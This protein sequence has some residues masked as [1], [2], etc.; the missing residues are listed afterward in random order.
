MGI[1]TS[2]FI[3]GLLAAMVRIGAPLLLAALGAVFTARAGIVNLALEGTMLIGS[4]AGFYGS[5]LTGNVWGGVLFAIIGGIM[6]QLLLA[7][8][9]V[10]VGANQSVAGMGIN[11][12]AL[13]LTTY[14][15]SVMFGVTGSPSSVESFSKIDVPI[16]SDI[17]Y[18]GEIFFH[19]QIL[20]YIAYLLV[21]ICWYVLFKTPFGLNVRAV[22]EHPKVLDIVGKSVVRT[23]V[24]CCV[25]AGALSGLAGAYLSIGELG[26]FTENLTSG[27]GYIAVAAVTFGKWNPIGVMAACLLFGFTDALQLRLQTEGVA[28]APQFLLMLPYIITMI[29]MVAVVGRTKAP[30]SMGRPYTK[31]DARA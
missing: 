10:I 16:L 13:G 24:T 19:H 6:M 4:F 11:M 31:H 22:G 1:F 25:I 23:R 3:V 14:L 28:I 20:V 26:S 15:L 12:F 5:Y 17:P 30:A 7:F 29:A 27:R 9:A 2:S 18:I 8:F 21:P